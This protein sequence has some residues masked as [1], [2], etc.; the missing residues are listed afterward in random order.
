M[1]K[2][3]GIT[4]TH[5]DGNNVNTV[6]ATVLCRFTFKDANGIM[7]EDFI[8]LPKRDN[9]LAIATFENKHPNLVWREFSY[10]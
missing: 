9:E 10:V 5:K 3:R 1:E 2:E 8:P 6:L 4:I 7:G